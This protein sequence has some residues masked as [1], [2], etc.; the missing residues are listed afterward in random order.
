[1]SSGKKT[2]DVPRPPVAGT[3]LSF[4]PVL[5]HDLPPNVKRPLDASAPPARKKALTSGRTNPP[6]VLAVPGAYNSDFMRRVRPR[7]VA[8]GRLRVLKATAAVPGIRDQR[9]EALTVEDLWKPGSGPPHIDAVATED[10]CTICLQLKSHPVFY[11]CGHGHCYTCV[12]IWLEEHWECPQCKATITQ[13]PFR[14][15]AVESFVRRIY[16]DWDTS[17]IAY[18]WS[19]LTFPVLSEHVV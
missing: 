2:K 15:E 3:L 16:G 14:I 11:T 7:G 12:R 5:K 17:T 6:A 13:E 18:D 19:G 10:N 4:F 9:D 1:M 8:V